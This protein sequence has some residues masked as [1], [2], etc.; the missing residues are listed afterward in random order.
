MDGGRDE[1]MHVWMDG[2][3]MN[4]RMSGWTDDEMVGKR[5]M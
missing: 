3:W 5:D 1:K 4:R 2:L